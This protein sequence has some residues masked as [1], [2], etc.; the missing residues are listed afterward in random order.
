MLDFFCPQ[1]SLAQPAHRINQTSFPV[2]LVAKVSDIG[3][4]PFVFVRLGRG[5]KGPF[6][7][8]RLVY[9]QL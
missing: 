9:K 1:T 3:L 2:F 6:F 7:H 4:K 8:R 5:P